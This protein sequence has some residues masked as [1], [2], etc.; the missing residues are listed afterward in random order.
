MSHKPE[1][2]DDRA[3][4]GRTCF[5]IMPFGQKIDVT[6]IGAS[7]VTARDGHSPLVQVLPGSKV[8]II[9]FDRVYDLLIVPA[10]AMAE[11]QEG[12]QIE[13][14]RSDKAGRS[15][16]I[17]RE[18]LGHVV[19]ADIA[20]VDITTQNANVFYELGVRHSFRR[21]TTILIQRQGTHIPFNISGMRVL[22]YSDDDTRDE[23]GGS[24]LKSSKERLANMIAASISQKENDS[25]VRQLLPNTAVVQSSW[26][27]MERRYVWFDVL[28]RDGARINF[29][30]PDGD[31]V[32]KSVGYVT[33]DILEIR[34]IDVWVNPENTKMQMARFHDGSIS[35]N[36]R[37]FG[38]SRNDAGHIVK[39]NIADSLN[40]RMRNKS[41]VEPGVVFATDPGALRLSN[42][43]RMLI[44]VAALNGEPGQG[45]QPIQNY[46]G[47]VRRALYEID[48]LCHLKRRWRM[49][50]AERDVPGLQNTSRVNVLFPL[51][52]TRTFGMDP[53]TVAENLYR[54]A[55]VF[56]QQHPNPPIDTV[57]FLAFTDD[58]RDL[59]ER[60]L[61]LLCSK[62]K[63]VPS[64]SNITRPDA[65][66]TSHEAASQL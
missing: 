7:A 65:V 40:Y 49:L 43:V 66:D 34:D 26:P 39:D 11:K 22:S 36:I 32:A 13:A 33:G 25:L 50:V 51:F 30:T 61:G 2:A 18:M 27:I 15:G 52:G 63:I 1:E 48:R 29:E 57:Y 31:T 56:L 62:K 8:E 45:Y 4:M 42:N 21:S 53:Q 46:P 60:A 23:K 54:A 17:P 10:I 9:D 6:T 16:F 44:H 37:Y 20:I 12:F 24:P 5:V 28:N 19:G 64:G 3:Y 47:C 59:C 35:S 38:A 55:V 58:D 14:I 41:N